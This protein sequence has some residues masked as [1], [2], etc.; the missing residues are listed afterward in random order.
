M[1]K[2]LSVDTALKISLVSAIAGLVLIALTA[3]AIPVGAVFGAMTPAVL[4]MLLA[5]AAFMVP[6]F[7]MP[8]T[9][10]LKIA[11][12]GSEGFHVSIVREDLRSKPFQ[13]RA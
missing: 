4:L 2:N 1:F 5:A 3:I 8:D 13:R 11:F 6:A 10:S 12:Y 9:H 7:I